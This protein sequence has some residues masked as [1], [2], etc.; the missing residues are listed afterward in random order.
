M[1]FIA[2]HNGLT[3]TI[4]FDF[5]AINATNLDDSQCLFRLNCALLLIKEAKSSVN[6]NC[7]IKNLC[8]TLLCR[9]LKIEKSDDKTWF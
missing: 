7:R 1:P 5:R 3:S 8:H 6:Q 9:I 4:L 2:P